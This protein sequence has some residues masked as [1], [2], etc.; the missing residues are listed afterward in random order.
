MT[1]ALEVFFIPL[2][3]GDTSHCV[4]ANGRIF[5]AL[6]AWHQR[7]PRCDL[8][9]SALHVHLD[10]RCWVVE[11]APEWS[12]ERTDRGVRATGPV[13]ARGLGRWALFR[14]EVRCWESGTIPDLGEAVGGPQPVATDEARVTALLDVADRFPTRTWGRDELRLGDMW[15]SNSLVSWLLVRSGHDVDQVRLPSGGRAPGWDAGVAVA[16]AEVVPARSG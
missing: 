1:A 13:G 15:N 8:Y 3:A 16:R 10:R 11:M 14:Y 7:R 6:A 2:G 4:R 12:G 9:H 5:E